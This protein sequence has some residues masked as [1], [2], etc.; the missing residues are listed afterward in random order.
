MTEPLAG[1]RVLDAASFVAGPLAAS[2]LADLGADVVK[3]EPAA[4]DPLRRIGGV[5]DGELSATFAAVNRGKRAVALDLSD[6]QNRARVATLAAASTIVIHNQ[7]SAAAE[8]LGLAAAPIVVAISAFGD[9][10][11]Y[12]ERPALDPIVQAMSGIA[13]I[14]GEPDGE[15]RR[16]GAPVVDVATALCAGFGAL[17][18]LR[19]HERTGEAKVI[20]VS[21]FEIGLL[22]NSPAF[23]M[24]SVHGRPLERLGNASHALLAEQFAAA[25]GLVWLA[26]WEDSQWRR[27][28]DMLGLDEVADDTAFASNALRVENQD[29]LVPLI[30]A[31]IASRPAEEIRS[32]L[33]DAG[34]PAAITLELDEVGEDPHVRAIEALR[35]ESRLPGPDLSIPAGP[36]RIDG[37]RPDPGSPA[38][39]LGQHTDEVL[40]EFER[41]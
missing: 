25:D 15:P 20:T 2:L 30:A 36:L 34:I 5:I 4:G 33:K 11:P 6:E 32:D 3:L 14:T 38:P 17:A 26:V 41:L 22:L 31:A 8:R 23:A 27:L 39:R 18:A 10:G 9:E 13:S 7:R 37:D 12:A 16:A 24:R 35:T 1:I 19:A 28:C 40:A 29:R 21:L